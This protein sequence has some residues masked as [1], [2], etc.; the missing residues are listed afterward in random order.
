MA[1]IHSIYEEGSQA[2]RRRSHNLCRY[3]DQVVMIICRQLI[4]VVSNLYK[5]RLL[6]VGVSSYDSGASH[7][8]DFS[9]WCNVVEGGSVSTV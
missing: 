2:C 1:T 6:P 4:P 3:F 8:A 5:D 7:T 9:V